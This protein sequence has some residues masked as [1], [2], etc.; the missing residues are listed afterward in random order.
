MLFV[1]VSSGNVCLMLTLTIVDLAA[2]KVQ[3]VLPQEGVKVLGKKKK[4]RNLAVQVRCE[5]KSEKRGGERERW[6]LQSAV[7]T[8]PAVCLELPGFGTK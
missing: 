5:R 6:G 4:Q 3:L 8:G 1:M 7:W 2:T